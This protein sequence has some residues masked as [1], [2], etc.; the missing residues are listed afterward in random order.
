MHFTLQTFWYVFSGI[1]VLTLVGLAAWSLK[2]SDT[3]VKLIF[4]WI[5][6][7]GVIWLWVAVAVPA[8][9]SGGY[10]AIHGLSLTLVCGLAMAILWRNA[11]IEIIATPLTNLFDGGRTPPERKPFYS[12]AYARRKRGEFA[13]AILAVREQLAKFPNDYEGVV[14]LATVQAEDLKDVPSAEATLNAFCGRD[15]APPKQVAAAMMLLADW[16]LKLVHDVDSA[17]ATLR[18]VIDR[19]PDTELSTAAAQRL[20]HLGGTGKILAAS[21]DRRRVVVPEGIQSAGLR[22]SIQEIVPKDVAPEKVVAELLKHLETHPLD[23]EAREKL[24]LIYADHYQRL[25]LA[26][27]QLNELIQQHA[28]SPKRVA[29]WLNLFAD[30]QIK[31]GAEYEAVCPTLEKII[32]LY[33]ELPVASLAQSR[34]NHL[35]LEIKGRQKGP[36]SKA[37]GEYEQNIGIKYGPTYGSSR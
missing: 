12:I 33:P 29:H 36:G 24:A 11:I 14:L 25:D 7:A 15:E 34:L 2:E 27:D 28:K 37:I 10:S 31:S 3:P 21:R 19:Y 22:D 17:A 5:L 35:K 20:A 9:K 32:E 13:E 18:R 30:L 8:A 4:K 6:S 1:G 23:T 16:Q 26:R